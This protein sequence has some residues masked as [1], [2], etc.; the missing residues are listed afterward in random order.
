MTIPRGRYDA[1]AAK[2]DVTATL[3]AP[4][5]AGT[6]VGEVQVSLDGTPVSILTA[7]G[8][9]VAQQTCMFKDLRSGSTDIPM[10]KSG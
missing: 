7:K 10:T 1:L 4:L 8:N 6:P 2:M 5:A 9:R 3:V